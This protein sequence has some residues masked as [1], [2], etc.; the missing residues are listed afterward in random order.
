MKKTRTMK[1]GQMKGG[2]FADEELADVIWELNNRP[3]KILQYKTA[4]E[5]FNKH[6][7]LP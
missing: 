4:Q 5:V 6:L 7:N 3:R 1:L 2:L